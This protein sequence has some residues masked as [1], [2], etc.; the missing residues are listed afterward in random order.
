MEQGPADVPTRAPDVALFDAA[1]FARR[2]GMSEDWVR[3]NAKSG[4]RL[5]HHRIGR[6]LKFSEESVND[7]K[8]R[9]A[10]PAPPPPD[11]MRRNERSRNTRRK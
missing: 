8:A 4:M 10:V 6:L 3:R 5:H 11:P 2:I 9:T 1:D 7:F